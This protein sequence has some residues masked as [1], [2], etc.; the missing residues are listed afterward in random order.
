MYRRLLV[1]GIALVLGLGAVGVRAAAMEVEVSLDKLPA[2]IKATIIK[3]TR[4]AKIETVEIVVENDKTTIDVEMVKGGKTVEF[5]VSPEGK[6]LGVKTEEDEKDEA[7]PAAKSEKKPAKH[8]AK[9][10]DE[11]GEA[12]SEKKASKHEAK[13]EDEAD[14]KGEAKSEKKA[15]KHKAKEEDEADEKD[16]AKSEKKASKHEAKDEDEGDGKGEAKAETKAPKHEAKEED[17]ADE[18]DAK[19]PAATAGTPAVAPKT[20]AK[21][22]AAAEKTFRKVYPKGKIE[23]LDV[24]VENGVTVYDIE[25]K[26]G[27][28]EMETDIAAN[29]TMLE[30][31]VVIDGKQVPKA[32]MKAI[33]KGSQGAALARIERIEISYETKNGKAV[34]LPKPITQYAAEYAKGNQT[35]E[36]T[37]NPDGSAVKP[38]APAAKS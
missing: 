21:L 32:A 38:D 37:V 9:E 16:K 15:S 30:F 13:E 5:S 10:E 14:E 4:G 33:K 1:A 6:Y 19:K 34:K 28:V 12:K 11:K 18:K 3:Q 24:D 8:E 25:F 17:E 36:V 27:P 20:A 29:G 35:A 2:N 26:N 22:T 31:T 7:K 23:K